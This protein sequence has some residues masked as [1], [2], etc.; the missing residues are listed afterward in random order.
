[1]CVCLF[2]RNYCFM[3]RN[4]KYLLFL[5]NQSQPFKI[6]MWGMMCDT[7]FTIIIR[8]CQIQFSMHNQFRNWKPWCCVNM[9]KNTAVILLLHVM[10]VTRSDSWHL[11]YTVSLPCLW[12]LQQRLQQIIT[13]LTC[14]REDKK[15]SSLQK[16]ELTINYNLYMAI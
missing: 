14:L 7:T 3:P 16:T 8:Y 1:M 6:F 12:H 13:I 11:N 15:S 2:D 10:Q 4:Y 9:N 5:D